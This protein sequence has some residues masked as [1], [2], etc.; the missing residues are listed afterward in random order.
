MT[1]QPDC[2]P[3]VHG[4]SIRPGS[5]LAVFLEKQLR[6]AKGRIVML[7]K[8]LADKDSEAVKLNQIIM[9]GP[10]WSQYCAASHMLADHRLALQDH[11]DIPSG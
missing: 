1:K 8:E 6:A 9:N 10:T 7:K 5:S 11:A 4:F 2:E 3:P